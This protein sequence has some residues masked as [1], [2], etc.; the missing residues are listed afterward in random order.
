[1]AGCVLASG[2]EKPFEIFG[3][4]GGRREG[5]IGQRF[6]TIAVEMSVADSPAW[7]ALRMPR[8]AVILVGADNGGVGKTT[9]AHT[10]LDYFGAHQM[11]T[12]AFDT[13]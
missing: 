13:E 10:L 5:A 12:R 8:P 3:D 7:R 6:P 2:A 9:V 4:I 1:V 11:P